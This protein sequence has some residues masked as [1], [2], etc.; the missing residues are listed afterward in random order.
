MPRS[1][2][3]LFTTALA[4][5]ANAII[6]LAAHA[7]VDPEGDFLLITEVFVDFENQEIVITG[8]RWDLPLLAHEIHV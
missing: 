5:I 3:V 6:F 4:C 7:T 8:H 1:I 2:Y